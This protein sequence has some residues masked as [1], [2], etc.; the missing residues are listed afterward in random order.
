MS[1]PATSTDKFVLAVA[2]SVKSERL[3]D[4]TNFSPNEVLIVV[5]KFWSS[6]IAAANSFKV[7]NVSGAASTSEETEL[8]T[9]VLTER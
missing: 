9:Y 2:G 5:E 7:F 3:L 6:P 8:S 1:V 4:F